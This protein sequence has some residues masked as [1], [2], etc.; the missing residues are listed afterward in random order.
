MAYDEALAQRISD[1]LEGE[2][3]LTSRKMFGGLGYMLDGHMAVAAG[4][5]GALMVRI[6]PA[7]APAWV[8]GEGVTPMKMR[9]REMAGWLL[10]SSDALT[11]DEQLELWVGRGVA[12]VRALPPR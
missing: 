7:D 1:V 4:S 8:D 12:F 10:V 9:G 2:P 5:G 6:D 11:S 3:G